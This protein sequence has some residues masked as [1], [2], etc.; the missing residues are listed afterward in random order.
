MGTR[1]SAAA[2]FALAL[3]AF[4]IESAVLPVGAGRDMERYVQ[5]FLQLG[6]SNPMFPGVLNERGPLAALGVGVPLEAGGWFA[7]IWLGVLYA[8]SIVAWSVV[9]LRFS[10][11]AAV[12][13]AAALLLNP[14]YAIL[15]HELASDSLFAAAFAGWA[16]VLTRTFSRPSVGNFLATGTGMG[17]LVLVRP[18]N[19]TLIVLTLFPLLARGPW[20]NKLRWVAAFYIGSVTVTQGWIAIKYLRWGTAV[21]PKPSTAVV[22]TAFVLVPLLFPS[23]WRGRLAAVAVAGAVAVV[24]VEGLGARNPVHYA[25]SLAQGPGADVFLFRT[26]ELER[27]I[28]PDN[29]PASRE[30]ARVA[31][32]DLLTKEPYRSYG[33][34]EHTLFASGSDRIF[35]DIQQLGGKVDLGA[36]ASEAIRRH[37]RRFLTGVAHTIWTELWIKRVYSGAGAPR[38]AAPTTPTSPSGSEFVVVNGRRLPRPSEGQ[39]IPASRFT[40]PLAT[41]Y[42]SAR[43]IWDSRGQHPLV[44]SDRRDERRYEKLN[45]DMKRLATRIPVHAANWGL[46]HRLNQTSHRFPPPMFWLALGVLAVALRRPRGALVA[47]A[48]SIAAAVVVVGNALV[49]AAVAEYAMPVSPAFVLLLAAGLFGRDPRGLVG[50]RRLRGRLMT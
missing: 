26:Y 32:R 19:Q 34:D 11:R 31:H 8:C 14:G 40:H 39:P 36:V 3:V 20:I 12:F 45:N 33:V 2:L 27:I 17:G 16:V 6:W 24:A 25:R 35:Q 23:P 49:G 43:E 41:R 18:G 29:G 22:A 1:Q 47:L 38:S 48:P 50:L 44:F 13:T 21:T 37:P 46:A 30:L 5:A 4:A 15:A 9:A 28:S 7:E 42:G 10:A